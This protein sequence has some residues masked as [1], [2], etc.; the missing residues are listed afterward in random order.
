[1]RDRSINQHS[2]KMFKDYTH[3]IIACGIYGGMRESEILG[4]FW[5]DIDFKY[6]TISIERQIQKVT[7]KRMATIQA[8]HPELSDNDILITERLK[9]SFSKSVIVV[10]KKLIDILKAYKKNS[11]EGTM[12]IQNVLYKRRQT[13]NC[14]G[15]CMISLSKSIKRSIWR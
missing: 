11:Y 2:K 10:P 9:T 3:A 13:F 12:S 5:S 6:N 1:M 4:L 8:E 15:F 14:S 7:K